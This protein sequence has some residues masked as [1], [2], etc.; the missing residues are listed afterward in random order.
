[1][2]TLNDIKTSGE[3]EKGRLLLKQ[4]SGSHIE[5]TSGEI[6]GRDSTSNALFRDFQGI[7]RRHAQIIFS[8]G[9][10]SIADLGSTNGTFIN[11]QRLQPK[12]MVKLNHGDSIRLSKEFEATVIHDR[13]QS[14]S[15]EESDQLDACDNRV[16]MTIMFVDLKGSTDYF[17]EKGTMVASSWINAFYKMLNAAI[18]DHKGR[19]IK[20][21][22]DAILAVFDNPAAAARA[23]LQM[24]RS[25]MQ[26]NRASKDS[27]HY[28]IKI[29]INTGMVL[30]ENNDVFGN[31]VNITSRIQS[32]A[33]AGHTYISE[34][35]Y[36]N[37]KSKGEFS[38]NFI[39]RERL[40][41][42]KNE[43]DIYELLLPSQPEKPSVRTTTVTF[44]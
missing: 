35:V 12:T 22:G 7:S 43:I 9:N 38:L 27:E 16:E 10:W 13:R 19:H 1:M 34:T 36:G 4:G 29:G 5:I 8:K 32:I 44:R 17:Q 20:N 3:P 14:G 21:I 37:I 6:L 30:N 11:G 39:S 26:H 2:D 41:G 42:I 25:T 23:A 24:Q 18:A 15:F 33:P 40:R 28:Y 31:A